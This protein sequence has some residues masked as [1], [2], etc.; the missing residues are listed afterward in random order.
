M[1]E[2]DLLR[3]VLAGLLYFTLEPVCIV[4]RGRAVGRLLAGMAGLTTLMA[5]PTTVSWN[6]ISS[7]LKQID[8]LRQAA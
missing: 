1:D 5:S 4:S 7:W 6:R 8:D 3:Q 2:R